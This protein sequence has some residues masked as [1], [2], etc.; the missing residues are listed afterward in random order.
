MLHFKYYRFQCILVFMIS[1][2]AELDAIAE[3]RLSK[4]ISN[5]KKGQHGYL[6]SNSLILL[7]Y[8]NHWYQTILGTCWDGIKNQEEVDIDCGGLCRQCRQR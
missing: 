8:P 1:I 6:K 4:G 3:S 7:K 2:V 5:L